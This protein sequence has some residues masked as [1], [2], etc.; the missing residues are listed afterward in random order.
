MAFGA[1]F[2][3][4]AIVTGGF[5][6]AGGGINVS[7]VS[8]LSFGTPAANRYLVAVCSGSFG[9]GGS[10]S[11]VTIGGVAAT[12]VATRQ[13]ATV[14]SVLA[15]AA[16]P[17]GASG[18]VA[19]TGIGTGPFHVAVYALYGLG[20]ATPS[21][22]AGSTSNPASMTLA[23]LPSG[24]FVVAGSEVDG[25]VNSWSGVTQDNQNTQSVFV[26]AVASKANAPAGNFS[27]SSSMTVSA[28]GP[29]SVAAAWHP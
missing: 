25:S 27:L 2:P 29:A 7:S 4:S 18:T 8:G 10:I 16:V 24:S 28:G 11:G 23:G 20:S 22:T 5:K 1:P 17:A 3:P 12:I 26:Q 13:N 14:Q 19:C 9:G 15:I 6:S 21:A